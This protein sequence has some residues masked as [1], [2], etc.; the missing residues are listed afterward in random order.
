MV[1]GPMLSAHLTW[2]GHICCSV[3]TPSNKGQEH[4]MGSLSRRINC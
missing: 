3:L 4:S 2:L 1:T